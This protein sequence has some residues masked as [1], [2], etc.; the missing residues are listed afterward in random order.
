MEYLIADKKKALT[1]Y[2]MVMKHEGFSLDPYKLKYKKADG[3]EV[4]EGFFTGGVGHK[5]SAEDIKE[6]DPT[7]SKEKKEEYWLNKYREDLTQAQLDAAKVAK[8]YGF[9]PTKEQ[10]NVLTS[11]RFQMGDK[12]LRKF[13]KF[14]T[15]LAA[16]DKDTAAEEML[17]SNWANQTEG[18]AKELSEI[19]RN[20]ESSNG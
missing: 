5:M 3:T 4:Q 9:T 2:G 11:M 20:D 8:D 14:L 1:L 15:A 6:F 13:K 17:D 7:W 10:H 18:R 16:G 12:G 19:I